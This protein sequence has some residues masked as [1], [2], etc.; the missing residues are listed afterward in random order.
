[1]ARAPKKPPDEK[2]AMAR[3]ARAPS[4]NAAAK[5]SPGHAEAGTSDADDDAPE[6]MLLELSTPV[7]EI[8]AKA[9]AKPAR[10][11]FQEPLMFGEVEEEAAV[12]KPKPAPL[13]AGRGPDFQPRSDRESALNAPAETASAAPPKDATADSS[14]S[15]LAAIIGQRAALNTL[16]SAIASRR[17]HHAWI[18]SG[19]YGTGKFTTAQAFAQELLLTPA[20]P[21]PM[22]APAGNALRKMLAQ[23]AH[24]DLHVI[25]KELAAVSREKQVR[26]SKQRTIAKDVISEF[27]LDPAARSRMMSQYPEG[28]AGK[29]FIIDEAELMEAP[30]QNQVLKTLEEPPLGT[31]IILVTSDE[32]RLLPT[33]RSRC[34]RVQFTPLHERDMQAWINAAGLAVDADQSPWLLRF[35]A[36]APGALASALEHDLHAWHRAL[37]AGL[38]ALEKGVPDRIVSALGGQMTKLVEERALAAIKGRPDAS[39]EA[40]NRAWAKRMLSFLAER[41][42]AVLRRETDL[43]RTARHAAVIEMLRAGE[44]QIDAN[45][46]H[47]AVLDNL[48]AQ[49]AWP[50]LQALEAGGVLD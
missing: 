41:T 6:P 22:P 20:G 1:M 44:R 48:A 9:A 19:P 8:K 38:G 37:D 21:E 45:V 15:P 32:S 12:E 17:V 3:S 47:G 2:G 29:V 10:A 34:Q 26:D 27:L 30:T 24:P 11:A 50:G 23:A 7:P 25:T 49:M 33:V 31:V 18:F 4:A 14:P 40:A 43:A 5:K 35:A 46:Q 39:K 28:L 36:G 13:T 42:R 16:R